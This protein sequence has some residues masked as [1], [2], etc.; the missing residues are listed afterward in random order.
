MTG[1]G[2]LR[3]EENIPATVARGADVVHD[4]YSPA[5]RLLGQI[6][7]GRRLTVPGLPFLAESAVRHAAG[8]GD[9]PASGRFPTR[10]AAGRWLAQLANTKGAPR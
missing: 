8:I 2:S 3:Y 1:K 10:A 4:V 5:G 6:L 7:K 9:R